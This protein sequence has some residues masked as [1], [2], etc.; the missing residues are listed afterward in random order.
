VEEAIGFITE[1]MAVYQPTSRRVWDDKEDPT[2]T[3][4]I[5]EG[6]RKPQ[7]L[8]EQLKSWMHNFV[9]ENVAQ[10]EDYRQ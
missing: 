1:Y 3:D 5:L 10:L 8:F 4:D 7:K 2:M 6:K 9:C